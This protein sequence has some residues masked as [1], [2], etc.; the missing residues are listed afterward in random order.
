MT[1]A[2]PE[3][4]SVYHTDDRKGAWSE[5]YSLST[6]RRVL[7]RERHNKNSYTDLAGTTI[8]TLYE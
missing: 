2:V 5:L 3:K 8:V 7:P 4:G 6:Y 1:A